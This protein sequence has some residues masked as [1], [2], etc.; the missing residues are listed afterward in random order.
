V[1]L[2]CQL[3]LMLD[4]TI[5][6]IA[7]RSIKNALDF[8]DASLSWV[9]NAYG[10][11]FGGL[12]L[13]GARAGDILG[14][15]RIFLAGI[16]L[17]TLASFAGGFA[18][19]SAELLA[20]RAA[21]G[22]GAA[23]AAPSALTLL[24]SIYSEARARTRAIGYYT[25]VTVGGAA[26]GLIAGGMLT[27][28]A[29]WRWV[30]F[31]NVPI[32]IAVIFFGRATLAET[33]RHKGR[34][35][36]A[37]AILSTVGI[38]SL[39]YG[40]VHAASD[41]WS[42]SATVGAFVAGGALLALFIVVELRAAT[43][44][45]PLQLFKSRTRDATYV[46][47]L[48]LVAAMMGMFYFLSQ[49]TQGVLGYSQLQSGFAFLPLTVFVLCSSQLSARFFVERFGGKA[50]LLTG[51]AISLSGL[52]WMTQLHEHS[53][54]WSLL[55]PMVLF[56][57]GNGS[58][59]VPLTSFALED[60]APSDAGAASGLVNVM[61]Q[62]GGA[63]GLAILVTVFGNASQ[64]AIKH[65]DPSLSPAELVKHG[66][67]AGADRAFW[68]SVLLLA[69]AWLTI[70]VLVKNRQS[71]KPVDAEEVAIEVGVELAEA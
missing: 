66:F 14:R 52:V 30:F 23:F 51:L 68:M 43:P 27:Q 5:V 70:A 36:L 18:H 37:G 12:L 59:F 20:S 44:I 28:W 67:V 55:G 38:T 69:F 17:F 64:N 7:L 32:G 58:S 15:R 24:M 61:Q 10:L 45:T 31:V 3:M 56:G 6:N 2:V 57:T 4:G 62:V 42:N 22:V 60:V 35:D 41:G 65:A 54:Y 53:S 25:A 29:S 11:A 1:I 71:S 13:L 47:R 34:F 8:N 48:L 26:V 63:L 46:A 19:N 49:F 33:Q 40:F 39:V 16:A 50:V 9:V 21:Q